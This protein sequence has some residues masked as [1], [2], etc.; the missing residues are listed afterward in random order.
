MSVRV[1]K[2]RVG[3]PII[4]RAQADGPEHVVRPCSGRHREHW[5]SG[6]I[7]LSCR[8]CA[9]TLHDPTTD[10][11]NASESA[12][13]VA[14]L[15]RYLERYEGGGGTRGQMAVVDA[16]EG[17]LDGEQVEWSPRDRDEADAADK[18]QDR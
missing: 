18:E 10:E 1:L 17:I 13:V 4:F 8:K 2:P 15:R 12:P 6:Y 7:V 14:Q 5:L 3:S 9:I 16:I 11:P